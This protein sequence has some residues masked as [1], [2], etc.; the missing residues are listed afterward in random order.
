MESV[1]EHRFS[2]L[3]MICDDEHIEA[4]KQG[5]ERELR[6]RAFKLRAVYQQA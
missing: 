4:L 2:G 6:H 3:T 1:D 5:Q